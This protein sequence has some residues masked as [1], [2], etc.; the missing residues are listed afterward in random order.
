MLHQVHQGQ[1]HLDAL[2]GTTDQMLASDGCNSGTWVSTRVVNMRA[3]Q[4]ATFMPQVT[5]DSWPEPPLRTFIT[6]WGT[7]PPREMMKMVDACSPAR[8]IWSCQLL[9]S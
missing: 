8:H 4:P 9:D 2:L 3:K 7:R 1:L 6:I 5:M